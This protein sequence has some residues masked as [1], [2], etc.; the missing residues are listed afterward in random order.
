MIVAQPELRLHVYAVFNMYAVYTYTHETIYMYTYL[1]YVD[2]LPLTTSCSTILEDSA[3]CTNS[4]RNM[5]KIINISAHVH[6]QEA[7]FANTFDR[8]KCG[9]GYE[10]TM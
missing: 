3:G 8:A 4:C 9:I 5:W 10:K 6:M 1:H 7:K 2:V